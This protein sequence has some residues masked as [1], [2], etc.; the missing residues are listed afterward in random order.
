MD[1]IP[2]ETFD[3]EINFLVC[4]GTYGR[5]GGEEDKGNSYTKLEERLEERQSEFTERGLTTKMSTRICLGTD[6]CGFGNRIDALRVGPHKFYNMYGIRSGEVNNCVVYEAPS[7]DAL[8]DHVL[9]TIDRIA[10]KAE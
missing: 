5:C 10:T 6:F 9:E 4:T 7:P 8:I 1:D 2:D 3:N